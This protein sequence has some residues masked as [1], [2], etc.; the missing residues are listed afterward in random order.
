MALINCPECGKKVADRAQHC[1]NCGYPISNDTLGRIP[2]QTKIDQ[3]AGV[4]TGGKCPICG[5]NPT[6]DISRSTWLKLIGC[7][8][9]PITDPPFYGVYSHNHVGFRKERKPGIRMG[10]R[11]FLYAPGGSKRIFALAEAISNPEVDV[12][13][14]PQEYGSCQWKIRVRY[15]INLP[16]T[17]G[18]HIDEISTDQR[19]LTLSIQ[20]QSHIKLFPA[21]Y[22]GAFRKLQERQA[23]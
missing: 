4:G 6:T 9:N 7:S 11:I 19:D 18:I 22:E 3:R 1:P 21:E 12:D 23:K 8:K 13:Y 20:R 10:D 5:L 14:D 16:V 17:S 15:L 2:A